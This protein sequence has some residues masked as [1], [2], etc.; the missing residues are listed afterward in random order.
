MSVYLIADEDEDRDALRQALTLDGFRVSAFGDAPSFYRAFIAAR[1]D[2]AVIDLMLRGESALPIADNL[3]A[4][5]GTGIV[6]LSPTS[7]IET[8]LRAFESGAD[9]YLGNRSMSAS[10][11]RRCAR[12]IAGS[13]A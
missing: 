5:A 8:R 13:T 1:C 3:R 11:R 6:V 7:S 4:H 10:W 9:S 2:M 12:S